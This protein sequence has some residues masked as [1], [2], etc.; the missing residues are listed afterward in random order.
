[1]TRVR[2]EGKRVTLRPLS[3]DEFEQEWASRLEMESSVQPILPTRDALRARFERSGIMQGVALDLAIEVD[4]RM[5]G[6]IQTYDPPDRTLPPGAFE[7]GI[8]I[9][10]PMQGK[11]YG[12]EAVR[13][14]VGWLFSDAGATRV[15]MPTVP[16]KVA[17]R[18]VA[19]RLGFEADGTI[20]YEGL[21]FVFYV[22]TRELWVSRD[23]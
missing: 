23:I 7:I 6:G 12:T 21:E 13:L 19:E 16:D 14:L 8:S 15:H 10:A 1:M 17:M 18:T 3:M 11:G 5:I 2:L 20:R 22:L 9:D 4:D